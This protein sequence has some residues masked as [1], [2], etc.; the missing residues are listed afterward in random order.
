[1]GRKLSKKTKLEIYHLKK[2]G[3]SLSD[4]HREYGIDEADIK[5]LIRLVDEYGDEVLSDQYVRY[6]TDFKTIVVEDY[7]A[8]NDSQRDISIEYK[9]PNSNL[10]KAWVKQYSKDGCVILEKKRG[11]PPMKKKKEEPNKPLEEMT[12]EEQIEYWKKRAIYAEAKAEY[13]KKLHAVV[14]ARKAQQQ[15]KK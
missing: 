3:R 12:P 14:Q 13:L 15:K 4:L 9:L 1:M 7:L 8:G 6:S 11:R 5:Y 10:L 2:E